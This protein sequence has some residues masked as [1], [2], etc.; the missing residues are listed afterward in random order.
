MTSLN[1]KNGN[2]HNLTTLF[3]KN[4]P[5]LTCIQVDN[6]EYAINNIYD[7]FFDE[8]WDVDNTDV[9]SEDC[10]LGIEDINLISITI[11]PNPTQNTLFIEAQQPIERVRIYNLQ[12]QLIAEVYNSKVDVSALSAG[13]YFVQ[14]SV[15]GK[16]ETK[17]FLKE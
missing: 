10:Y 11:Y 2:N 3:A 13:L 1:L 14:V 4:N 5:A 7:S 9:Y 6:V 15:N 16:S 12:G 17:K 8:G